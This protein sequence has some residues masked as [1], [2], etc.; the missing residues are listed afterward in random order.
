MRTRAISGDIRY[1]AASSLEEFPMR[2]SGWVT[3]GSCCRTCDRSSG[4]SFEAQP[5]QE[6]KL[7]S[8]SLS[9]ESGILVLYP[10][11]VRI[12]DQYIKHEN[13][14]SHFDVEY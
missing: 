14:C 1:I 2:R 7:V 8:R 9:S 5:A 6:A 13:D 11:L 10:F 3:F 4:L 12:F